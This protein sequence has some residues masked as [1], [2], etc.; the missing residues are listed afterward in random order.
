MHLMYHVTL[1]QRPDYPRNS[2]YERRD[3]PRDIRDYFSDFH[4]CNDEKASVITIY[5]Y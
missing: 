5:E 3:Y 1:S 2:L 4:V